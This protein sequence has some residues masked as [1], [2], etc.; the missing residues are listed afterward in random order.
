MIEYDK[1]IDLN[2]TL[3]NTQSTDD[4]IELEIY[5]TSDVFS[6]NKTSE[7]I[8]I[9]GGSSIL[10]ERQIFIP[11]EL[12]RDTLALYG[13]IYLSQLRDIIQLEMRSLMWTP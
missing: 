6:L 1:Y 13:F 10:L 5:A 3:E 8:M 7:Q 11:F 12:P 2:I 9:S 4:S